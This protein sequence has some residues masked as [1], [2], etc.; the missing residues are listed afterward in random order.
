MKSI[1]IIFVGSRSFHH[2]CILYCDI[3]STLTLQRDYSNFNARNSQIL[4]SFAT[5]IIL[6]VSDINYLAS[7]MPDMQYSGDFWINTSLRFLVLNN[8]IHNSEIQCFYHAELDNIIFNLDTLDHSLPTLGKGIF[9][10]RD[11][12]DRAIA[13]LIFCNRPESISELV[14]LFFQMNPPK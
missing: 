8:F 11:S 9:V 3:A 13:S 1:P 4:A 5:V 12:D 14:N 2:M 7:L 6:E 10:P